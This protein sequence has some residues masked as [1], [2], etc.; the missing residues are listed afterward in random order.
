MLFKRARELVSDVYYGLIQGTIRDAAKCNKIIKAIDDNNIDELRATLSQL[1]RKDVEEYLRRPIDSMRRTPLHYAAWAENTDILDVL[2]GYIN[3]PDV[4]DKTGATPMMFV[5]GSGQDCL[6]KMTLLIN[7]HADVNRKDKSGWTLLHA[8]VQSRK[9]DILELLVNNGANLHIVDGDFRSLLHIACDSGDISIVKYLVEK[10]VSLRAKD[11]N[12]WTPL[13]I[14]CGPAD[15]YELVHYLIQFGADPYAR[16]M[17]HSTPLDLATQFKA[18][19]VENYLK[20]LTNQ[21]VE[22][23]VDDLCSE[24]GLTYDTYES[25]NVFESEPTSKRVS[26][27]S[28]M[29]FRMVDMSSNKQQAVKL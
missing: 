5:V 2:L 22:T 26:Q 18:K 15:D 28:N 4:E 9:R 10:G 20:A 8:A 12:G 24:G 25:D 6:K 16:D 14:A 13:H 17:N 3:E 19:N 7:K 1:N 23:D 11:K 27:K 29:S 21:D